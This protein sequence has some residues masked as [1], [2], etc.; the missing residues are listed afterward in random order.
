MNKNN[1]PRKYKAIITNPPPE[2]K[3]LKGRTGYVVFGNSLEFY[4]D[5][6]SEFN[7]HMDNCLLNEI[8]I[9]ELDGQICP[10]HKYQVS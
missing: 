5:G 1:K 2:F 3:E 8:Y 6:G 9:P 4:F 7:T 10:A